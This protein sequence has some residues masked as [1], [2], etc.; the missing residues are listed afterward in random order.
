M[1]YPHLLSNKNIKEIDWQLARYR[2]TGI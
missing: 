1:S 2:N